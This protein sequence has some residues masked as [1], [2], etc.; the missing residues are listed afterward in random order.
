MHDSRFP[1]VGGRF[2]F[3]IVIAAEQFSFQVTGKITAHAE[4]RRFYLSA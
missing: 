3:L 2:I 1:M 4:G